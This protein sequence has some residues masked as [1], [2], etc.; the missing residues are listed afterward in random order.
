MGPDE[1]SGA[2]PGADPEEFVVSLLREAGRPLTTREIQ[3]AAERA[4][5]QCPDSTVVF[6]NRLRLR[7]VIRGRL[8]R[9]RRA[10][11]WW[12]EDR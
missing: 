3:E 4:L 7:G 12:V 2:D 8:S 1:H 9:E 10:W 11:V 5:V 6:L